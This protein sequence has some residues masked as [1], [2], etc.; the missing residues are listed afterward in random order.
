MPLL[1][2][3]RACIDIPYRPPGGGG[4]GLS[5]GSRRKELGLKKKVV[6]LMHPENLAALP[7]IKAEERVAVQSVEYDEDEDIIIMWFL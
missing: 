7:P 5:G 6:A 3:P 2:W 1:L 4:G